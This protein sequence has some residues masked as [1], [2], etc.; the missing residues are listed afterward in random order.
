MSPISSFP[1][2]KQSADEHEIGD[3]YIT[4]GYFTEKEQQLLLLDEEALRETLEEEEAMAEKE[5]DERIRQEQAY[6]DLFRVFL[7]L[8]FYR[9]DAE[10]AV[11]WST[12]GM[13]FVFT[14]PMQ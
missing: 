10:L 3:E 7:S 12:N 5:W 8:G 4:D 6:D 9:R 2:V 13:L 11:T 14:A 1:T